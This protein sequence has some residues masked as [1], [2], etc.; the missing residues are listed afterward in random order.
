V[1]KTLSAKQEP[2]HCSTPRS[3]QQVSELQAFT[4]DFH[5]Q[6]REKSLSRRG[7]FSWYFSFVNPFG[8]CGNQ[9]LFF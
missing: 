7:G 1:A 6:S 5:Q 2:L 3:A 9:A 8:L 4:P